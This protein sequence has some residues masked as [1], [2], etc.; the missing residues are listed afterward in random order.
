MGCLGANEEIRVE[1]DR[2]VGSAGAIHTDRNSSAIPLAQIA[3][4]TQSDGDILFGR[5]KNLAHG[6]RLQ[7]LVRDLAKHRGRVEADLR[8]I[9]RRVSGA[10]GRAVVADDVVQRRH[11]IR[12]AEPLHDDPVDM[13]DRPIDRTTIHSHDRPDPYGGCERRPEMKF[14]RGVRAALG[15]HHAPKGCG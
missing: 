1:V 5:E 7:R 11:Q 14:V 12:I 8:A 13:G 3:V 2:R 6:H 15:G 4:H 9:R 10:L